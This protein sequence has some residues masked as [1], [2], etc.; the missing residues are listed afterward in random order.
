LLAYEAEQS[1]LSAIQEATIG[2]LQAR[3]GEVIAIARDAA[4]LTFPQGG[5]AVSCGDSGLSLLA[6]HVHS[7]W[8]G[9]L[10]CVGLEFDAD[11]NRDKGVGVLT[12]G[13][14][15]FTTGDADVSTLAWVANEH[16]ARYRTSPKK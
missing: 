6:I 7:A 8:I 14:Q 4:R 2:F 1:G 11:W 16:A 5:T 9:E 10:A 3:G 13:L 12:C 15:V